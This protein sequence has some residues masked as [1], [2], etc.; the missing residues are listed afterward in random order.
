MKVTEYAMVHGIDSN[1]I[2][3]A[4]RIAKVPVKERDYTEEQI[5]EVVRAELMRRMDACKQKIEIY[6]IVMGRL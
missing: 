3:E 4:F 6:E 5:A 1:L 2:Y